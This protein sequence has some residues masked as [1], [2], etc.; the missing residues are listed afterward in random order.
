MNTLDLLIIIPL[1]WGAFNGYRKGLLIEIVGVAAF[2]I[3]MIVGFKFLRFGTDLL[4]P[5]L[6]AELVRRFLPFVGFSVIFFP[7]VFMVNRLG[8]SMR[9]MLRYTLLGTL[10]NLAGAAVGIFTWVFGISVFFWLLSTVGIQIPPKYRMESFLYDYTVPIAPQII[11]VISDWIPVGGN[12][13]REWGRGD[14]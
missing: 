7:T 12:L 10:D 14:G 1:A 8:Y 6:T 9:S 2:V 5:Y 4:A 13:I 3:A 11:S